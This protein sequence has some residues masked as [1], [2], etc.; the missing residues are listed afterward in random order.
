MSEQALATR[1]VSPSAELD[2]A[3][4]MERVLIV[5][6]LSKLTTDE[7][8]AYYGAVCRSVGLNPLTKPFDYIN[9][10]GKLVLYAKKDCSEQ[11]RNIHSVSI[12]S[13]TAQILEGI[14]VVTAQA[15]NLKGR[16]DASTGAVAIDSLKGEARANA[17]MKAE[18]KAKRRVTLS[19]CGLG[20]P[21]ESE[22]EDVS[23]E[24][25]I[26]ARAEA[27]MMPRRRE[28]TI[29]TAVKTE[30]P[31]PVAETTKPIE[32]EIVEP[33][34]PKTEAAT[35]AGGKTTFKLYGSD[36]STQGLTKEQLR[37]SFKLEAMLDARE[38]K[39]ATEAVL[40]A[41]GFDNRCNLDEETGA[42]F[43]AALSAKLG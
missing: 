29:V 17:M 8:V 34:K 21:D 15:R 36:Y 25:P 19:I 5:G 14:Y 41:F 18:T 42:K 38:G 30:K 23:R 2:D 22:L 1:D 12:E 33:E 35:V 32:P 10:N 31:A 7:R 43:L 28:P 4:I 16:I 6:D 3:G 24:Q 27:D 37:D 11:L 9:L 26:S 20:L 13:I 39:G 40:K